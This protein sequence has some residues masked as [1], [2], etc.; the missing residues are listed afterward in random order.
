MEKF[1]Q[2][3]PIEE[4]VPEV[5]FRSYS[6]EQRDETISVG[7][8]FSLSRQ[9]KNLS[10]SVYIIPWTVDVLVHRQYGWRMRT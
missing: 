5:H 8:T 6:E 7:Q 1:G 2:V 4:A 3:T 9:V 10:C